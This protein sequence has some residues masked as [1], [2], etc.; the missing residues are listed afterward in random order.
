MIWVPRWFNSCWHTS[1]MERKLYQKRI[2][3]IFDK[4]SVFCYTIM[5]GAVWVAIQKNIDFEH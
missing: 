2:E 4:P 3:F 5:K 1:E